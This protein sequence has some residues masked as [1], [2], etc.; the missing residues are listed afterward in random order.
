MNKFI[1]DCERMKYADTGIYH[2]CLNL[3]NHLKAELDNTTETLSYYA[4][5]SASEALGNNNEIITQHSA[6]KFLMPMLGKFDL[7]HAT[8]Q[9]TSYL[10]KRNKNIKVLLTIHDLNFIHD[11]TKTDARRGSTCD[12]CRIISNAAM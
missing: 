3:G 4:P 6:H 11:D 10:P 9:M 5:K 2:Y 8:Y 1:L 12:T 7:W